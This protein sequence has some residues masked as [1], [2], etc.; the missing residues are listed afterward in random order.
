MTSKR[1]K[2]LVSPNMESTTE[3]VCCTMMD[4]E[5]IEGHIKRLDDGEWFLQ[6]MN[7]IAF[8]PFCGT[9]LVQKR[10][11]GAEGKEK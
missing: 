4:T 3:G 8:C 11:D 2:Y 1:E 9:R 5:L 6:C 10:E 7:P